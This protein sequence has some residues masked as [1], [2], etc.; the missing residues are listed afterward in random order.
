V[1]HY[2]PSILLTLYVA[3]I[4]CLGL[5]MDHMALLL[6]LNIAAAI[7]FSFFFFFFL[8]F[9]AINSYLLM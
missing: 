8:P 9:K 5:T 6:L 2:K 3:S 7:S 4:D 1:T